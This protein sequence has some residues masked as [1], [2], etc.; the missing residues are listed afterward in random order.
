MSTADDSFHMGPDTDAVAYPAHRRAL[1]DPFEETLDAARHGDS[2]AFELLFEQLGGAVRSFAAVRGADDPDGLAN[3]VLAEVFGVL[4]RFS[5][6][7]A[8][9]RGFTFQVARRRLIDD[10]RRRARRPRLVAQGT[11][12]STGAGSGADEVEEALA[13]Q[14]AL[15]IVADLTA[16]QRDVILLRVVC[17]LSIEAT[18]AALDKPETAIKAL[19]RRAVASLRRK[20]SDE[21][22]S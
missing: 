17:D 14:R 22:V 3:E 16:D 5:G 21:P 19:Q 18:A 7:E 6:G 1:T 12:V 8:A 10:Y 15:D 20:L 11:D 4:P 2:W 9:L 13:L